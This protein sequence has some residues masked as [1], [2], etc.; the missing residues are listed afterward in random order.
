MCFCV[1]QWGS[2]DMR[3]VR[4]CGVQKILQKDD[5]TMVCLGANI[6]SGKGIET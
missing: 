2:R 4:F 6:K 5:V 1:V 3:Q